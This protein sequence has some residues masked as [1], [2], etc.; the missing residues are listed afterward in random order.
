MPGSPVVRLGW[1][2]LRPRQASPNRFEATPGGKRE[3]VRCAHGQAGGFAVCK[4]GKGLFTISRS[5]AGIR[6]RRPVVPAAFN[7]RMAGQAGTQRLSWSRHEHSEEQRHWVPAF[8]GMTNSFFETVN[9]FLQAAKP[10]TSPFTPYYF[11]RCIR[12]NADS[13]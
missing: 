12:P 2:D 7:S 3:V 8:A 6:K 11:F 13:P 10:P 9:R 4:K 1:I 5:A